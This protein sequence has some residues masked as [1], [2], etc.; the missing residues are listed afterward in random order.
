MNKSLIVSVIAAGLVAGAV[1]P[2]FAS[3]WDKAGK[4]LAVTEGLRIVTGGAFDILGSITG[5]RERTQVRE[6]RRDDR[7]ETRPCRIA[8]CGRRPEV[9][10]I[11]RVWVPNIVWKEKFVPEHSE[12][13]PGQG[14]IWIGSHYEKYQVEEGGH[15]EE[16]RRCR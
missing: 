12:F 1:R 3:D 14:H 13:R 10:R 2:G 5:V 6:A 16:V 15:W 8:R 7:H 9:C 4:V 11:E